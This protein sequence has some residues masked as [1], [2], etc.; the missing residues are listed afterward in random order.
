MQRAMAE[1]LDWDAS[2]EQLHSFICVN[3]FKNRGVSLGGTSFIIL[4]SIDNKGI[5]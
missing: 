5:I 3:Y 1:K 4:K 2:A